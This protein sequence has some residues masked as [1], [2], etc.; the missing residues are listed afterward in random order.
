MRGPSGSFF[1]SNFYTSAPSAFTL[2]VR[3]L[4]ICVTSYDRCPTLHMKSGEYD[5]RF[6]VLAPFLVYF[7]NARQSIRK[8]LKEDSA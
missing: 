8:T 4:M 3:P 7:R 5:S 1:L 6:E 2:G